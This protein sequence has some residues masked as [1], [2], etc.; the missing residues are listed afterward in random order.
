MAVCQDRASLVR[1]SAHGQSALRMANIA[2]AVSRP[3]T[4][5][6]VAFA[7]AFCFRRC[8]T[9]NNRY[10]V[11]PTGDNGIILFCTRVLF[12]IAANFYRR[13]ANGRPY[14]STVSE[15]RII[16]GASIARPVLGARPIRVEDGKYRYCGIPTGDNGCNFCCTRAPIHIFA[17]FH[18]RTANGRPYGCGI[19]TCL[20]FRKW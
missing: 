18:R 10:C 5:E 13:T 14:G 12:H 11:S 3:V 1:C 16:V 8:C 4:Q 9:S 17:N 6:N 19:K 7:L 15:H 20:S 2:I